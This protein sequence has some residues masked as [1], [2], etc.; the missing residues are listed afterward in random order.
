MAGET[1]F[2]ERALEQRPGEAIAYTVDTTAYG[3]T[4]TD[5][6]VS[7]WEL[8]TTTESAGTDVSS[9]RLSGAVSI[10]GNIIT[11]PRVT[12][13]AGGRRYRLVVRFTCMGNTYAPAVYIHAAY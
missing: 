12:V 13:E 1:Y 7:L 2:L 8:T 6:A 4:P 10:A 5:L 3:G 9:A 11:T